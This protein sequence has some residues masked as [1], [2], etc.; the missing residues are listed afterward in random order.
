MKK[1]FYNKNK[2]EKRKMR[3]THT[4]ERRFSSLARRRYSQLNFFQEERKKK[5]TF[6][7]CLEPPYLWEILLNMLQGNRIAK[8][9]FR[10]KL[11]TKYAL[12][13]FIVKI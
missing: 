4:R 12:T 13:P 11:L 1:I 8:I 9:C 2:N 6:L 7:I 10:K 3:K 5:V